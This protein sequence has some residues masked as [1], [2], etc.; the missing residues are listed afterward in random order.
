ML[1]EL[2]NL[3]EQLLFQ[4]KFEHADFKN[5]VI[6]GMGGSGI[7]GSIFSEI[8]DKSPIEI[9]SEY[10]VPSYVNSDTLFIAISYSGNTE[11]TISAYREAERKGAQTAAITSGGTIAKICRNSLLIPSGLQPRSA[12]GYMLVPLILSLI[13]DS[14]KDLKEASK[15]VENIDSSNDKIKDEARNLVQARKLPVIMGFKPFESVAYRWQTQFNENSKLLAFSSSFPELDHN[16]IMALENSYGKEN[17]AFYYFSGASGKVKERIKFT[18]DL[19][20]IEAKQIPVEGNSRIAQIMHLVHY[21]DY[22]SYYA[23]LERK[24]EPRDVTTIENLKKL[25]SQF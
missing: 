2:K 8:Y 13:P 14:S 3:K 16:Q 24:V 10:Y 17:L 5:I 6:A 12:L 9:I 22:F 19:T 20:G 25:L 7:A 1:D 23:A 21:G 11:E 4:G 15:V 18:I